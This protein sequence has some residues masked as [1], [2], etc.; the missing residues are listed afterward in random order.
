[1]YE[2]ERLILKIIDEEYSFQVACYYKR[3]LEYLKPWETERK[4]I[5]YT[6]KFQKAQLNRDLIDIRDGKLL[7]LWIF[8]KDERKT[9]IG[10]ISFSNIIRG[11]FLSCYLGYKLDKG[12]ANN[13]YITEAVKKGIEII[14]SEYKLH[15]IEACIMINNKSS[16]KVVQKLG[17]VNEGITSSY[18][19]ID[20]KWQ[21][22]IKMVLINENIV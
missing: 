4:D 20:G 5:F 22:H 9:L 2:T 13:G 18:L 16:L 6:V 7:R 10:N 14:F 15:R 21:D 1:M 19:K 8:K 17:F 11:N 12:E 3:N